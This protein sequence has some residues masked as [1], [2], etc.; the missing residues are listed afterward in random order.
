MSATS[1]AS[2]TIVS[3]SFITLGAACREL[4]VD[5]K[6]ALAKC[7]IDLETGTKDYRLTMRDCV[8]AITVP[9]PLPAGPLTAPTS[10]ETSDGRAGTTASGTFPTQD[11]TQHGSSETPTDVNVA[12]EDMVR[13]CERIADDNLLDISTPTWVKPTAK[14]LSRCLIDKVSQEY[15]IAVPDDCPLPTRGDLK[16]EIATARSS[17]SAHPRET[18]VPSRVS[19]PGQQTDLSREH[20]DSPVTE[21]STSHWTKAKQHALRSQVRPLIIKTDTTKSSQNEV[22]K[23]V[24]TLLGK[25]ILKEFYFD[26]SD[27]GAYADWRV[28]VCDEIDNYSCSREVSVEIVWACLKPSLRSRIR[29]RVSS[30]D[31]VQRGH[32]AIFDVLDDIYLT[33]NELKAFSSRWEKVVQLPNETLQ[34]Y[35]LRFEELVHTRRSLLEADIPDSELVQKFSNGFCEPA[36][37]LAKMLVDPLGRLDYEGFK[38]AVVSFVQSGDENVIPLLGSKPPPG[39]PKPSASD[40]S[41]NAKK[42]LA[43][44]AAFD[45]DD[46]YAQVHLAITKPLGLDPKACLRC[47]QNAN[48]FARDCNSPNI[49]RCA[50]RCQTCGDLRSENH[51]CRI[52]PRRVVCSRCHKTGHVAGVC[53]S[54][55][56]SSSGKRSEVPESDGEAQFK[57]KFPV[58]NSKCALVTSLAA[59]AVRKNAPDLVVDFLR[60][61]PRQPEVHLTLGVDGAYCKASCLVDSGANC[62]LISSGLVAYLTKRGVIKDKDVVP[63]P[64]TIPVG[65]ASGK[66]I[67]GSHIV[68]IEFASGRLEGT[69]EFLVCDDVDPDILLGTNMFPAIGVQLTSTGEA[70]TTN[71]RCTASTAAPPPNPI[72]AARA[73]PSLPTAEIVQT[74]EG[75]RVMCHCGPLERLVLYPY[76][77]KQRQLSQTNN[78]ILTHRMLTM[79]SQGKVESCNEA[80]CTAVLAAVI[81]DKES[82]VRPRVYPDPM[83]DKRYRVTV[84]CR[85]INRL[86]LV[87]DV[88]DEDASMMLMPQTMIADGTP[89]LTDAAVKEAFRQAEPN[90]TAKLNSIPFSYQAYYKLDLTDAYSGVLLPPALRS[91]FGTTS[92]GGDG[93]QLWWVYKVLPQ[94]WVFSSCLFNSAMQLL[95]DIINEQLHRLQIKA[96]C[97]HNKDDILIAAQ[98]AQNCQKAADVAIQIFI[99]HGFHPNPAKSCGP[100]DKVHFCGVTLRGGFHRP[101]GSRQAFTESTYSLAW[102]EF[103]T[104]S[105]KSKKVTDNFETLRLARL[106]WLRK[107]SGTMNYLRNHLPPEALTNL[108]VLQDALSRYQKHDCPLLQEELGDRQNERVTGIGEA[109]QGLLQFYLSGIPPMVATHLGGT[110]GYGGAGRF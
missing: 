6:T 8:D 110:A 23:Q 15:R 88:A 30:T 101:E 75:K 42:P 91:I 48:H 43:R 89:Q 90:I 63:L 56:K 2:R 18:I 68:H 9:T 12:F 40:T 70:D 58:T 32:V 83:V 73:T 86:V 11:S 72:M 107:W 106:G 28:R 103:V 96:V 64:S 49:Y 38:L 109:F 5:N 4:L 92:R 34:D 87:G 3:G 99:E 98:D 59:A 54:Q 102:S 77:E 52:S 62:S 31:R 14:W 17:K 20:E 93:R 82:G 45:T 13:T 55:R 80:D 33:P 50:D 97:R 27:I 19:Y 36:A 104:P 85:P 81:C 37:I 78:Q 100:T 25:P 53:R 108:Y 47:G 10:S 46:C 39:A 71:F 21:I 41:K 74:A 24:N 1:S 7:F 105:L 94:G 57:D 44:K 69:L 16:R 67:S 76:R 35:A 95:V 79:A 22:L 84:D 51:R 60:R 26:G 65:V 29:R 66:S 61:L